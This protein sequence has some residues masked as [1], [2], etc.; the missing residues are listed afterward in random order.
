MQETVGVDSDTKALNGCTP[1]SEANGHVEGF[2][3]AA[4]HTDTAD[5]IQAADSS[6]RANG[7]NVSDS[8]PD[9]TV[10]RLIE[11]SGQSA[12]KLVNLLAK[13]FR[14]FQDE[15]RFDGR[16]VRLLKRAQIFVADLWAAFNGTGYGSF[17][18]IDHL[19]MFAGKC[20]FAYINRWWISAN[21]GD[22]IRLS[23]ATVFAFAWRSNI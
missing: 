2:T 21:A 17:E 5:N 3:N 1:T 19:T 11:E 8:R 14:C 7:H 12:G 18:D 16:K 15:S 20:H 9:Y 22:L 4:C 23:C 13:H 6:A 10:I